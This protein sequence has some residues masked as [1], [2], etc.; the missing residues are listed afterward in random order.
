MLLLLSL[1]FEDWGP[2][3]VGAI[4]ILALLWLIGFIVNLFN[5]KG[6]MRNLFL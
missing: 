1:S 2:S 3:V 4:G 5:K 6:S